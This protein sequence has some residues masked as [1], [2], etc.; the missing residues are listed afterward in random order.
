MSQQ[1]TDLHDQ[2]EAMRVISELTKAAISHGATHA[3]FW[4]FHPTGGITGTL[5]FE[6]TPK[7]SDT[8]PWLLALD[9]AVTVTRIAYEFTAGWS[10]AN[11]MHVTYQG[12]KIHLHVTYPCT[13][14]QAAEVRS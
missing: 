14:E 12:Q 6:S 3:P 13:A 5:A 11:M 10:M 2:L 8:A 9:Q 4:R 7:P 1:S